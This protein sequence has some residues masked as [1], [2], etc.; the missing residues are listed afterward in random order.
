[1][2]RKRGGENDEQI[3]NRDRAAYCFYRCMCSWLAQQQH[4]G[5]SASSLYMQEKLHAPNK[6]G[7]ESVHT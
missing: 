6:S 5:K 2:E 3:C 7:V 1:M 4:R